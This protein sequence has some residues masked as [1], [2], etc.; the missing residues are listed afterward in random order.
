MSWCSFPTLQL[1][2]LCPEFL[3]PIYFNRGKKWI[4]MQQISSVRF[5]SP[6]SCFIPRCF[7]SFLC[8]FK[9]SSFV[10]LSERTFIVSLFASELN[11]FA[12]LSFMFSFISS[13]KSLSFVTLHLGSSCTV[14]WPKERPNLSLVHCR[15]PKRWM[16]NRESFFIWNFKHMPIVGL[17]FNFT[18]GVWWFTWLSHHRISF[19]PFVRLILNFKNLI[20]SC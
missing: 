19:P 10:S 12:L 7:L 15:W 13:I 6:G 8:V 2:F 3:P 20:K 4:N 16:E 5:C 11:Y 14:S 1:I 18:F 9:V 17:Q